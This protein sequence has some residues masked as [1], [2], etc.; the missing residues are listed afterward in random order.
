MNSSLSI[1]TKIVFLSL[2]TFYAN[3]AFATGATITINSSVSVPTLSSAMLIVLSLLLF[4]V[5][6][7]IAKQKNNS[8]SKLFV[9]LLGVSAIVLGGGG[10]KLISEVSAGIPTTVVPITG[11]HHI[12]VGGG[13][14][15]FLQNQTGHNITV[16]IKA[17]STSRC[18]IT[19]LLINSAGNVTGLDPATS[20]GDTYTP[21]NSG[22]VQPALGNT[23]VTGITMV[24]DQ[25][26]A[27][28]C[29]ADLGVGG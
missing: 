4:V 22:G 9:S 3:T 25:A 26:C 29:N 7:K 24:P 1:K 8:A 2:F 14:F 6:F 23:V 18:I 15:G 28:I 5:A 21:F 10:V 27:L 13:Y 20:C 19:G 11:G 12:N 17:D 16:S